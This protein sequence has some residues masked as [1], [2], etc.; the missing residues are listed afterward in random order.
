[1][2]DISITGKAEDGEVWNYWINL[3]AMGGSVGR[4]E[5]GKPV[6]RHS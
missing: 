3:Y 2:T 6:F 4:K 1:M 5:H